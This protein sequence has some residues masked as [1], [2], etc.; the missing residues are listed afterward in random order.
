MAT[1][2]KVAKAIKF[3]RLINAIPNQGRLWK[4][5]K[6]AASFSRNLPAGNSRIGSQVDVASVTGCPALRA[7][8]TKA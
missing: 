1:F 7:N 3:P 6:A 5:I 4:Q 8:G 2:V